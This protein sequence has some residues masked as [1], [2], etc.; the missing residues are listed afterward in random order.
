MWIEGRIA[1]LPLEYPDHLGF[2]FEPRPAYAEIARIPSRL[3]VRW[4]EDYPLLQ[5]GEEWRLK[6]RL[7]PPRALVNFH[8]FDRERALFA[9]RIGALATVLDSGGQRLSASKALT[10]DSV[11]NSVREHI[12]STLPR[13]PGRAL[14]LSLA[15]ADRSE[16]ESD[17]WSLLRSTGT[18][19]LL[20]ISGLHIGLAAIAGFWFARG[21]IFLL[22]M[23]SISG[24]SG[25][26][27]CCL[28]ALLAALAY[29]AMAGFPVSTLRAVAMVAVGVVVVSVRRGTALLSAWWLAL[30]ATLVLDPFAPLSA[31]F[32]LSFG[33]VIALIIFFGPRQQMNSWWATLPRAQLAVMAVMLPLATFWFQAG[34]WLALPANLVAIP[35]VSLVTVPLV[36]V[37]VATLPLPALSGPLLELAW[38]S[39]A[40]LHEFL[41]ATSAL[42]GGYRWL[43]PGVGLVSTF[44]ALCGAILL[45]L[46]RGLALRWLGICLLLIIV[47]P[48]ALELQ[49][50][51]YTVENLDVGQ[52]LAV[53]VSTR[54]HDLLYDTGPGDGE[55]WSLFNAV[56]APSLTANGRGRP[57]IVVV[58][59]ADLDHAGGLAHLNE[60]YG[61][62][63]LRFNRPPTEAEAYDGVEACHDGQSWSWDGVHF[64]VLHPSMW[65]PYLGNDS[66]CVIS[67]DNGRHRTLLTGDISAAIED[68]LAKNLL[69][70]DLITVPH[71]GSDSSS[72][73]PFIAAAKPG[74]AIVSAA[75]DNR[76]GFPRP[77]VVARYQ[78]L[79]ADLLS[80]IECGA[81]RALF[82]QDGLPVITSARRHRDRLW[83]WHGYSDCMVSFDPAMY[84]LNRPKSKE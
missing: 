46:P 62:G 79:D 66:S 56:I 36:L 20:A 33:A 58:S 75:Y 17:S 1:S 48:R 15:I 35:W 22:P 45:L 11:R 68:R 25:F 23:T 70:H 57:D 80:T 65:L 30:I 8:G 38:W 81:V 37:A 67:I 3:Q 12:R 14:V 9:Q 76:F 47:L 72:G 2:I 27:L 61:S 16:L 24:R 74:I 71:H 26:V 83:R 44:L 18:G 82:P 77:E 53:L 42:E 64:R 31:G 43:T 60:R 73:A 21:L 4:F 19:H 32:W 78:H 50:G 10:P 69:P 51:E 7:R 63:E 5:P 84:H 13:G 41:E 40:T 54:H 52:G 55:N 28:G 59:H 39:C 29:G 34:S 49:E 6:L